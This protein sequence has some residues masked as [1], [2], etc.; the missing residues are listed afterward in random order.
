MLPRATDLIH[1][2]P[3][4]RQADFGANAAYLTELRERVSE[5]ERL[6]Q[7]AMRKAEFSAQDANFRLGVARR[8]EE[9]LNQRVLPAVR[10]ALESL[11]PRYSTGEASLSEILQARRELLSNEL[12]A[13]EARRE[14]NLALIEQCIQAGRTAVELLK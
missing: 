3:N 13:V 2:E 8:N 10:Q 4:L 6:E 9:T 1:P 12:K 7:A 14:H 5:S 11:L